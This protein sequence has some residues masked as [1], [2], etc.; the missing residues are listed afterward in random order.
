MGKLHGSQSRKR[1]F[2]SKSG[3]TKATITKLR[4]E[5]VAR[6]LRR[7]ILSP[8]KLQKSM[9]EKFVGLTLA[10]IKRDLKWFKENESDVWLNRLGE[11]GFTFLARNIDEQLEEMIE[12]IQTRLV[13][14]EVNDMKTRLACYRAIAELN[15][16]RFQ[17]ALNG[18]T[19]MKIR[20]NLSKHEELIQN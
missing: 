11:H 10:M 3:M 6:Y 20:R 16:H 17:L 15:S 4:R 18:P 2:R 9:E 1:T 12:D 8:T 19:L 14:N 13:N 7:G 5:E